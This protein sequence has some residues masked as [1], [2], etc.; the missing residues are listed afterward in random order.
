MAVLIGLT[1]CSD[2]VIPTTKRPSPGSRG[3]TG[4]GPASGTL[5]REGGRGSQQRLGDGGSGFHR[6]NPGGDRFG[7]QGAGP[8]GNNGFNV[9]TPE[10]V[11]GREISRFPG[12]DRTETGVSNDGGRGRGPQ[13]QF[14]GSPIGDVSPDRHPTFGSVRD[15][16]PKGVTVDDIKALLYTFNY[17]VGFH[18]HHEDGYRN[19]DKEGD[20]FFDGR[21][22]VERK[23]E[24]IANEFGYQPNITFVDL[25]END[26]R[27]P[28]ENTEK[29]YGLKGYE[30]KWF[31]KK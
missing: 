10:R 1:A 16:L 4:G 3:S 24:Y 19:G 6:R 26:L 27:R 9:Q 29:E 22:G 14:S 15:G 25:P 12:R 8:V 30:F 5:T 18:G 31:Y 11:A 23:V 20:Y 2:C 28:H 7:G 13:N 21:D 17:T